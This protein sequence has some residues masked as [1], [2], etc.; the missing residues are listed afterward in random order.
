MLRAR[1]CQFCLDTIP[2]TRRIDAKYCRDSCKTLASHARN[3][4]GAS[5]PAQRPRQPS[6]L[7][8]QV[9]RLE[10]HEAALRSEL[11]TMRARNAELEAA[12]HRF[13]GKGAAPEVTTPAPRSVAVR[14]SGRFKK[15]RT[16]GHSDP[17][18]HAAMA[19][20]V[21]QPVAPVSRLLD[22]SLSI[23]EF[24]DTPPSTDPTCSAA[25][26]GTPAQLPSGTLRGDT[27]DNPTPR[28]AADADGPEAASPSSG[29]GGAGEALGD[30]L[31][32][33]LPKD[34][35]FDWPESAHVPGAP[36]PAD[37]IET[38]AS[39]EQGSGSWPLSTSESGASPQQ[40]LEHAAPGEP[41]FQVL[42]PDGAPVPL[43]PSE[44]A[45]AP[46]ASA[47]PEIPQ[48]GAS[49]SRDDSAQD[50]MPSVDAASTDAL[51]DWVLFQRLPCVLN[52]KG[53]HLPYRL[54]LQLTEQRALLQRLSRRW[55]SELYRI[56]MQH[57]RIHLYDLLRC[58]ERAYDNLSREDP[59]INPKEARQFQRWR[60]KH[61]R[62][63]L[64]LAEHIAQSVFD[65][66]LPPQLDEGSNKTAD[67]SGGLQRPHAPK[68]PAKVRPPRPA[69][70]YDP[71]EPKRDAEER[72]TG[73]GAPN[74]HKT[75][76]S[77]STPKLPRASSEAASLAGSWLESVRPDPNDHAGADLLAGSNS[78]RDHV[79]KLLQKSQSWPSSISPHS[80]P[81]DYIS[82]LEAEHPDSKSG[83][84]IADQI[85]PFAATQDSDDGEDDA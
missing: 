84:F 73:A 49:D 39:A 83:D 43:K 24:Q 30:A 6:A 40:A 31:A 22:T 61:S 1:H 33:A 35:G 32:C 5:Q 81:V 45:T 34:S 51:A 50:A 77:A 67:R 76:P 64:K 55:T 66:E 3:R 15:R 52:A 17:G 44:Q 16:F 27:A 25:A 7:V 65:Q 54:T 47:S 42:A 70:P 53:S 59:T 74:A 57:P 26:H 78:G 12:L 79:G 46:S 20:A 36:S 18:L 63:L 19:D 56:R 58:A 8:E 28:L 10:S 21:A 14:G 60:A 13:Q 82:K 80:S 48:T 85:Q 29:R 62:L 4:P 2:P 68:Q 71:L 37:S 38:P 11:A 69:S 23:T 72:W 9:M 41:L 75:S